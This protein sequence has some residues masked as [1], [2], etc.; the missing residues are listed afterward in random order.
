MAKGRRARGEAMTAAASDVCL[1]LQKRKGFI[2]LALVHGTPVIPTFV[3]GLDNAF[4]YWVPDSPTL[5]A[6][7]RK[8]G[9]LPM[10]F[11]GLWGIPFGP[12]KPCKLTIAIGAPLLVGAPNPAPTPAQIEALHAEYVRATE[13]L[14]HKHKAQCG[15]EGVTLTII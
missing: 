9:M 5:D 3:F 13:R 6:L 12:P 10:V 14:Y 4:D 1:Y 8:L 7:G 15:F 11:W 2:K